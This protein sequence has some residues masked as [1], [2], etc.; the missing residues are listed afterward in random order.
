MT[1][2]TVVA[3]V[4]IV[5][6][7]L[8]SARAL[9]QSN[10]AN[11]LSKK[12]SELADQARREAA[13]PRV[14]MDIRPNEEHGGFLMLYVGNDGPSI[15]TNIRITF[16]PPLAFS[17]PVRAT[18]VDEVTTLL[19]SGLTSLPPGRRLQ[20]A[21]GVVFEAVPALSPDGY[22]VEIKADGP[23]GALAPVRFPLNVADIRYN[24]A[25]P[26]GTLNGISVSLEKATTKIVD[27]IR[28]SAKERAPHEYEGL[29]DDER[30]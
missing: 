12:S 13:D 14:W 11:R 19:A 22:M 5:I 26:P 4:A 28:V 29:S 23:S 8:V 1:P 15:A 20:W 2:Q 30:D 16:D 7:T 24:L 27:A 3:I 21:L 18:K 10:V 6:S 25:A 9:Y 17:V